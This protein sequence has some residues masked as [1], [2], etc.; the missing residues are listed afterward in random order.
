[1]SKKA[2]LLIKIFGRFAQNQW[3]LMGSPQKGPR[4]IKKAGGVKGNWPGVCG[5]KGR[6]IKLSMVHLASSGFLV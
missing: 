2:L 3:L 6:G 4:G 5:G 1:M